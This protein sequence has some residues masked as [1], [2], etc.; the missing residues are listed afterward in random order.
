MGKEGKVQEMGNK[1]SVVSE[2]FEDFVAVFVV[3]DIGPE[4]EGS[5]C[6]SKCLLGHGQS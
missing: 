2:S 1:F 3:F 6:D 4:F 5:Q